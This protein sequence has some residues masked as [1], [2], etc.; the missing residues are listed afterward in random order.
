MKPFLHLRNRDEPNLLLRVFSTASIRCGTMPQPRKY[1]PCS[2]S[3]FQPAAASIRG[4][5]A[6][7]RLKAMMLT[8]SSKF[9]R[10]SRSRKEGS[11]L[12]LLSQRRADK[13][14]ILSFAAETTD[15]GLDE[16][17]KNCPCPATAVGGRFPFHINGID[18][19]AVERIGWSPHSFAD[20]QPVRGIGA[21]HNENNIVQILETVK[22]S[23]LDGNEILIDF[24]QTA[25]RDIPYV[26]LRI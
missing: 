10:N 9:P 16:E 11:L 24:R 21:S 26:D 8:R 13:Y 12:F 23:R 15:I 4:A 14:R 18:H 20:L 5:L 2:R 22:F 6:V 17:T 7:C 3:P 25:K 19:N 1:C